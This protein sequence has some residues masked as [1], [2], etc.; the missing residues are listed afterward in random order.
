MCSS[1]GGQELRQELVLGRRSLP[2]TFTA[3]KKAPKNSP[4]TCGIEAGP[5]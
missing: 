1:R 3:R 2:R 4:G 5:L